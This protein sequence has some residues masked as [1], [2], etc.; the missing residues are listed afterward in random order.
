M[1]RGCGRVTLEALAL[2]ADAADLAVHLT[3]GSTVLAPD[4][5]RAWVGSLTNQRQCP[6][7]L[8]APMRRVKVG[9]WGGGQQP[10]SIQ[11]IEAVILG[12][13][14]S[15]GMS[16]PECFPR[17]KGGTKGESEDGD[18]AVGQPEVACHTGLISL[19][20]TLPVMARDAEQL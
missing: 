1:S 19:P 9:C 11:G 18:L 6:R 8:L 5:A 4:D 14:T 15:L 7:R 17:Q 20:T 10:L 13:T 3:S 12:P 2:T 16:P